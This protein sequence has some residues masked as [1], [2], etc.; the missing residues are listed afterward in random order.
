[1]TERGVAAWIDSVKS[2]Q[3]GTGLRYAADG[4]DPRFN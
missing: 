1:M 4:Q 2:T 3:Y